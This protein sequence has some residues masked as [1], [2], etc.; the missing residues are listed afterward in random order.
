[1]FVF[2]RIRK[3]AILLYEILKFY[4]Y[5]ESNPFFRFGWHLIGN[6][7][8][9]R[10]TWDTSKE[11]VVGDPT[12]VWRGWHVYAVDQAKVWKVF[13]SNWPKPQKLPSTANGKGLQEP[14]IIPNPGDTLSRKAS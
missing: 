9:E 7:A 3:I 2:D 1:M 4:E 11:E 10:V 8:V 13:N 14:L 12:F 5:E 6:G